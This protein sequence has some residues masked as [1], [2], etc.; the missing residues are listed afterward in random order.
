MV[1]QS[2]IHGSTSILTVSL[3]AESLILTMSDLETLIT[4]LRGMPNKDVE[5]FLAT[6]PPDEQF[7]IQERLQSSIVTNFD[8]IDSE[9]RLPTDR[10]VH[11]Y[12]KPDYSSCL[13]GISHRYRVESRIGEGGMGAVFLARD[14]KL[15]RDV[16]LKVTTVPDPSGRQIREA[17]ALAKINSPSVVRVYDYE[18]LPNGTGL[19]VMECIKGSDLASEIAK[20]DY[21]PNQA[22][23]WMRSVSDGMSAAEFGGIVHR[24]LKPSNILIASD[25]NA[26]VTDFGLAR[27]TT[28][29]QVTADRQTL[30][31]PHYIAPEQV[32]E[33]HAVDSRA[34]IYSFGAT[35]YHVFTGR[36]P[37]ESENL[38]ALLMKHKNEP[39]IPP[40]V[41]S[42]TVPSVIND[43]IERCMCKNPSDRFRTFSDVSKLLDSYATADPWSYVED[44]R[45]KALERDFQKHRGRFLDPTEPDDYAALA[46]DLPNSRTLEIAFGSVEKQEVDAVVSSGNSYLRMSSGVSRAISIAAGPELLELCRKIEPI[47]LGRA[48][49]T[50]GFQLPA[51]YVFH[52]VTMSGS[53]LGL[54]RPSRDI[55]KEV[56]DACF[57]HA[58]CCRVK[59][60]AFP[61]LG[62]GLGGFPKDIG[63]DTMFRSISA[64]LISRATTVEKV[65]IVLSPH[66]DGK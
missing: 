36:T 40:S 5:Q 56:I 18:Q 48:A 50:P 47:G 21:G 19:I 54:I 6:L 7:K 34:D 13:A 1:K 24:D 28:W 41:H 53:A 31:T 61:L 32:D 39:L 11:A 55:I 37:F 43:C 17:R 30:G 8:T 59:S 62:T 2:P 57:F 10:S 60:I 12:D 22:I 66:H 64:R 9:E 29:E 3:F 42:D 25:G 38:F 49:V 14:L 26:L 44:E 46:F 52:G 16:A 51:K 20:R 58:E 15:D 33:S 4:K 45:L 35:F 65:R 63:L 23:E 27:A